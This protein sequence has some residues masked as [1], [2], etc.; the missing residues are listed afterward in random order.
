[1]QLDSGSDISIINTQIGKILGN[2]QNHQN[3]DRQKNKLC[4]RRVAKHTF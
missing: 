1:M 2:Q 3:R 4:W